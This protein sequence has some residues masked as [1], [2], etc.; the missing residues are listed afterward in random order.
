MVLSMLYQKFMRPILF[1]YDP[2]STHDRALA[3][4]ESFGKSRIAIDAIESIFGIEEGQLRQTVF[5]VTFPNP[6]GLA[7]GFD[8]NAV[9]V[10][11]WPALGFGFAEIGSVTAHAQYGNQLPRM[12]RIVKDR[13]IVNRMGFNNDGA[14]TIARRLGQLPHRIPIGVNVGKSRI[15]ELANAAI[16]YTFT[17]EQFKHSADFF[18]T[19]VSSPNTPGLRKLQDKELLDDLLLQ[20]TNCVRTNPTNR[21][22]YIP[23]PVLV[24]LSPDLT[25][26][27]IDQV[28]ELVAKHAIAGI[29]ATNTTIK[30][31]TQYEG[32]MSGLP[33]RSRSTECIAHISKQTL[34][35]LPIIGVGGIFSASDAYEK[36]CAGACLVEVW[37]GL[38]YEGPSIALNINKGLRK[39]LERDGFKN[40][41]EAIGSKSN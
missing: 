18:V 1:S 35:K 15:T 25:F 13:A 23:R 21:E 7:A 40:I 27:Q 22:D 4:V 9:G 33:L 34:G 20:I 41:T 39:L 19:N 31:S 36:I 5:G 38:V 26:D 10:K 28:I 24:K 29:V 2:E 8:K 12:F 16:D 11:F 37:T 30:H 6:V 14:T 17:V 3:S 32:G